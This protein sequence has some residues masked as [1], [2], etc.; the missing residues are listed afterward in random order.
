MYNYFD[1]VIRDTVS[2]GNSP[3]DVTVI[4]FLADNPGPWFIHWLV[5]LL[6]TCIDTYILTLNR[7]VTLISILTCE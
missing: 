2:T 5:P 6:N 4:R 7:I 1:P 3:D